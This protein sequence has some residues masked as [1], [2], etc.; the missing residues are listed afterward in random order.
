MSNVSNTPEDIRKMLDLMNLDSIEN[1]FDII[2][3]KYKIDIDDIDIEGPL[4]EQA[5]DYRID[6]GKYVKR[7]LR[8]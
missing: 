3:E 8:G 2:P 4:S 5:I 6:I 7:M 1:L